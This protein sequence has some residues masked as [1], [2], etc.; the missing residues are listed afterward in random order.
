MCCELIA[1][2][3][4][5]ESDHGL[6]RTIHHVCDIALAQCVI[7]FRSRGNPYNEMRNLQSIALMADFLC[8]TVSC[9]SQGLLQCLFCIRPN[10]ARNAKR[11]RTHLYLP[12]SCF[13]LKSSHG[14][15]FGVPCHALSRLALQQSQN[16]YDILCHCLRNTVISHIVRLVHFLLSL[17]EFA[18]FPSSCGLELFV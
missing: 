4:S 11:T 16:P 1:N 7:L 5:M 15:L 12:H 13:H 8:D 6:T 10:A 9:A 18:I 14:Y 3:R 17:S 2:V